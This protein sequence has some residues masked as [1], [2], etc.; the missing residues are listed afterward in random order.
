MQLYTIRLNVLCLFLFEQKTEQPR[1]FGSQTFNCA[2]LTT[3]SKSAL[4]TRNKQTLF[5]LSKIINNIKS[6][7]K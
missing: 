3:Y 1:N 6:C 2:T 4:K 7:L 5:K